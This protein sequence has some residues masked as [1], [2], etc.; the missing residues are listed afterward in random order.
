MIKEQLKERLAVLKAELKERKDAL[1]DKIDSEIEYY[2]KPLGKYTVFMKKI[3]MT[4]RKIVKHEER[5]RKAWMNKRDTDI[6][7]NILHKKGNIKNTSAN[8]SR[9]SVDN[10]FNGSYNS[11]NVAKIMER[12]K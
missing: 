10:R 3:A 9:Y 2:G 5:I 12:K 1:Q 7:N 11:R 6:L 4:E 8:K